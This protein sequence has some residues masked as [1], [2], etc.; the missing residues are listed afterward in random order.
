MR[1]KLSKV[2]NLIK[3]ALLDSVRPKVELVEIDNGFVQP[4][5][6]VSHHDMH[7]YLLLT[8]AGAMKAFE[9]V[10]ELLQQLLTEGETEKDLTPSE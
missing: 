9:P 3:A 4:D 6:T 5:G 8:N 7:D 10:H 1:E 2:N